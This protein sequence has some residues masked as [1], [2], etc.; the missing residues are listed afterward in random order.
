MSVVYVNLNRRFLI[1]VDQQTYDY[2]SRL[3]C[4]NQMDSI[5]QTK[6]INNE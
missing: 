3:C 4:R 1:L 5:F 6:S 2:R